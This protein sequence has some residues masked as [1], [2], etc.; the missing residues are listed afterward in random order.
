MRLSPEL[1]GLIEIEGDVACERL[2]AGTRPVETRWQTDAGEIH[3][4]T[5]LSS[6]LAELTHELRIEWLALVAEL[7]SKPLRGHDN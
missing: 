5:V 7:D 3:T 1:I 6:N 4:V 2:L